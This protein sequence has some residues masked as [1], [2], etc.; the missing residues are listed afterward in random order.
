MRYLKGDIDTSNFIGAS[1][2]STSTK[3]PCSRSSVRYRKLA[4]WNVR[5]LRFISLQTYDTFIRSNLQISVQTLPAYCDS[6]LCSC[7][8]CDEVSTTITTSPS[9]RCDCVVL[10]QLQKMHYPKSHSA[11]TIY[12]NLNV[13]LSTIFN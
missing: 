6:D 1:C 10:R 4:Y 2:T 9:T 3:T 8:K 13:A 5:L 7:Y 11:C 12:L